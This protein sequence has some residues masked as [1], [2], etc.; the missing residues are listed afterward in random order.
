M[1]GVKEMGNGKALFEK[2]KGNGKTNCLSLYPVLFYP[3]SL[4]A[5]LRC[6]SFQHC[7]ASRQNCGS[8]QDLDNVAGNVLQ[9]N[10]EGR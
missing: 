4:F 2:G 6:F 9:I 10:Q 7:P 1:K 5:F 3:V 8:Q